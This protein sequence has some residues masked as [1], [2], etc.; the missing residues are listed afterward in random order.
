MSIIIGEGKYSTSPLDGGI[1][2]KIECPAHWLVPPTIDVYKREPVPLLRDCSD[3]V[4]YKGKKIK[5]HKE[6]IIKDA[7]GKKMLDWPKIFDLRRRGQIKRTLIT[8]AEAIEFVW[9]PLSPVCQKCGFRCKRGMGFIN[10]NSIK[11]LQGIP[12]K[13]PGWH[14]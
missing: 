6:R 2:Q 8:K 5:I 14:R 9:N 12:M 3:Y 1:G 11:R 4:E 13:G 7:W 10:E